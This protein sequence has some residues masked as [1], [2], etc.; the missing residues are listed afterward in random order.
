[1]GLVTKL[2]IEKANCIL[3][4]NVAKKKTLPQKGPFVY[5]YSAKTFYNDPL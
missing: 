5:Q 3:P 4:K 2:K 1:V